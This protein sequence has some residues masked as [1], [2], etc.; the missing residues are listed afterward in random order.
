MTARTLTSTPAIVLPRVSSATT[1]AGSFWC[2]ETQS[3]VRTPSTTPDG[4][5]GSVWLSVCTSPLGSA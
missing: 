2:T 4:H 1:C 5:S 3:S